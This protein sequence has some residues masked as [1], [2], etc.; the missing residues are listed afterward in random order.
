LPWLFGFRSV[1]GEAS[2]RVMTWGWP[3]AATSLP[4]LFE[5]AA[6]A[7]GDQA[8]EAHTAVIS[9]IRARRRIV[10]HICPM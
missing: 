9:P 8:V 6:C 3:T 1:G 5:G 4:A 2:V 7:L 10:D